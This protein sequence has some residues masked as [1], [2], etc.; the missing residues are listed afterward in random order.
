[1]TTIEEITQEDDNKLPEQIEEEIDETR[2][3]I[4]KKFDSIE[5]T[6][7][8]SILDSDDERA[9]IKKIREIPYLTKEDHNTLDQLDASK[10]RLW[11]MRES[12]KD[13]FDIKTKIVKSNDPKTGDVVYETEN[14]SPIPTLSEL[15]VFYSPLTNHQKKQLRKFESIS[16]QS[17]I[18]Y[19]KKNLEVID[20]N[21][22]NKTDTP[23]YWKA[24]EEREKLQD[25]WGTNAEAT[26]K[27]NVEFR[28]G[29]KASEFDH[30]I[31]QDL[32]RY[33]AVALYKEN[34]KNP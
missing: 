28:L 13:E 23:E 27:K 29:I 34:L 33:I 22:K 19:N 9:I 4:E 21:I 24:I 14:G 25:V 5:K 2:L 1:M 32:L 31:E 15:H 11:V 30:L 20:L 6:D 7:L 16:T 18:A 10:F 3:K 12:Q 8:K 17:L 26:Q